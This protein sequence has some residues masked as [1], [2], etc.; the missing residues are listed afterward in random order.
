VEK[1]IGFRF[2]GSLLTLGLLATGGSPHFFL[3]GVPDGKGGLYAITMS[4]MVMLGPRVGH[5]KVDANGM[6]ACSPMQVV[7][8]A[9]GDWNRWITTDENGLIL[10]ADHPPRDRDER[11]LLRPIANSTDRTSAVTLLIG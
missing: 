7:G 6:M 1:T 2:P 8:Q 10:L 3:S 9:R 5:C 4:G 11:R